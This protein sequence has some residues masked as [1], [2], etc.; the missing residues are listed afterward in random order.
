MFDRESA[1]AQLQE[2]EKVLAPIAEHVAEPGMRLGLIVE[3]ISREV[4]DFHAI[5]WGD[6][7]S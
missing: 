5:G 4:H 2:I 7:L 1:I 6:I 3:N